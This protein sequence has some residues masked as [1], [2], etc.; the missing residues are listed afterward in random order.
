MRLKLGRLRLGRFAR[1]LKPR[2]AIFCSRAWRQ[3]L[4]GGSREGG[5]ARGSM[6]SGKEWNSYSQKETVDVDEGN[7]S[8]KN[9]DSELR[10]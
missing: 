9:A 2:R 1:A 6:Y 5:V 10:L 7:I 8:A 4:A 3:T